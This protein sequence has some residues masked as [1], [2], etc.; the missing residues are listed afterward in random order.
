M[1]YRLEVILFLS[2]IKGSPL[3]LSFN[4]VKWCQEDRKNAH[5]SSR[6]KQPLIQNINK[7]CL[8]SVSKNQLFQG[9]ATWFSR[10]PLKFLE[11]KDYLL[12]HSFFSCIYRS[13]Y[14]FLYH[15]FRSQE[16]GSTARINKNHLFS[17]WNNWFCSASRIPHFSFIFENSSFN[18]PPTTPPIT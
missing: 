14:N 12:R 7:G 11:K 13:E 8:S 16:P 18:F 17:S 3:N 4:L 10:S 1:N 2:L 15:L 9:V 6:T 5:S